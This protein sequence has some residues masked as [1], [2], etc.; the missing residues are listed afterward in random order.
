MK[1]F[2]KDLIKLKLK[3]YIFIIITNQSGI[4]LNKYT[5]AQMNACHALLVDEA[6]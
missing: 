2:S 4:A 6:T 5:E 1:A 3:G